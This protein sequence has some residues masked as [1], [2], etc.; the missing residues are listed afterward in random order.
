MNESDS[1]EQPAEGEKL[2]ESVDE[3]ESPVADGR[4][5][6]DDLARDL[7]EKEERAEEASDD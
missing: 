1:R 4:S 6:A 2:R 3:G 7:K 5:S